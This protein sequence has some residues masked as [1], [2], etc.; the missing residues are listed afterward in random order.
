MKKK[1]LSLFLCM[2]VLAGALTGCSANGHALNFGETVYRYTG[3]DILL[4]NK[5]IS[6]FDEEEYLQS[7]KG[8]QSLQSDQV[9]LYDSMY[10]AANRY[11]ATVQPPR[12]MDIEDVD[13][14]FNYLLAD[15]GDLWWLKSYS[16]VENEDGLVGY[17]YLNFNETEDIVRKENQV[18]W[19]KVN[20]LADQLRQLPD[21]YSKSVQLNDY[22]CNTTTYD[23]TLQK[24]HIYDVYGVFCRG[25][26]VCAGY[27]H[28]VCLVLDVLQ[29]DNYY[30]R[31]SFDGESHAWTIAQLDGD[32]YQLDITWNDSNYAAEEDGVEVDQYPMYLYLNLTTEQMLRDHAI[33]SDVINPELP[34]CT[35]T[36]NNYYVREGLMLQTPA[37]IAKAAVENIQQGLYYVDFCT[38][39][40]EAAEQVLTET[41]GQVY[42]K[43]NDAFAQPKIA[44]SYSYIYNE[45]LACVRIYFT[46][47]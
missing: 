1:F 45:D 47:A 19:E 2:I 30:V 4:N 23:K 10:F 3:I 36:K 17:L 13:R 33:P 41:M 15:C 40:K 43:I 6:P 20:A 35:A 11:I 42:Q 5:T 16:Y 38:E 29:I 39:E 14:V 31:G 22:I 18:L 7:R 9:K 8:R 37:Q 28:A 44:R 32:Y 24:E 25:E 27:A 34:I 12:A 21:D 26:A 46:P